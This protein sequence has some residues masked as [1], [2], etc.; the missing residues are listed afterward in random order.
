MTFPVLENLVD[1]WLFWWISQKWHCMNSEVRFL[2]FTG[3]SPSW[4]ISWKPAIMLKRAL[5]SRLLATLVDMSKAEMRCPCQHLLPKLQI[6]KQNKYCY[7]L[8]FFLKA[9]MDTRIN[10]NFKFL[11]IE[12]RQSYMW[13]GELRYNKTSKWVNQKNTKYL[14]W[15]L[16]L[17]IL[18]VKR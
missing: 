4:A 1:L 11:K 7:F 18:C 15:A 9:A 10:K 3:F 8:N 5:L 6:C 2:A 12:R 14:K 13:N 16:W 17:L